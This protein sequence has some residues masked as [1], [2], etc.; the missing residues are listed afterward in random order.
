MSFRFLCPR[1]R[2]WL[3][4]N[5]G[6]VPSFWA[7]AMHSAQQLVSNG[8]WYKALPHAGCALEAAK[9]MVGN[10]RTC[11]REWVSRHRASEALL[12]MVDS[13]LG[14]ERTASK[15]APVPVPVTLH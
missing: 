10:A 9:L 15:R 6:E 13:R 3:A 5:P 2:E 11:D 7:A 14:A 4:D 12:R 1:H 8:L